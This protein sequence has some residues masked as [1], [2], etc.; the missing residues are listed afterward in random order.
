M[1]SSSD[2]LPPFLAECIIIGYRDLAN[3][4]VANLGQNNGGA[5]TTGNQTVKCPPVPSEI[6]AAVIVFG[7]F[8]LIPADNIRRLLCWGIVIATLVSP[9]FSN[10]VS[11]ASKPSTPAPTPVNTNPSGTTAPRTGNIPGT[12]IPYPTNPQG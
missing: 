1:P 4:Q 10:A 7:A 6:L 2:I 12:I 9:S 8:S 11:N 5:T 3:G